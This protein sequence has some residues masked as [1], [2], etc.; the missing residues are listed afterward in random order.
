MCRDVTAALLVL[1][2][3]GFGGAGLA[4]A[5][6]ADKDLAEAIPKIA[7]AEHMAVL[8]S[9]R[10]SGANTS[11]IGLFVRSSRPLN[12]N[13]PKGLSQA[14]ERQLKGSGWREHEADTSNDI[15]MSSWDLD[16]NTCGPLR[17]T[18]NVVQSGIPDVYYVQVQVIRFPPWK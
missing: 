13:D 9:S 10:G 11:S 7:A 4:A 1:A 15:F 3:A 5:E 12:G 17:G 18:L 14:F 8:S 16:T 2:V 6:C